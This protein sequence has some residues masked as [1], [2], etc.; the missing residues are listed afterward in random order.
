MFRFT[1]M[2]ATAVWRLASRVWLTGFFRL[3]VLSGR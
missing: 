1:K 2:A 3:V